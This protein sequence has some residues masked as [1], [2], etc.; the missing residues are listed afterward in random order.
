MLH[1][2]RGERGRRIGSGRIAMRHES[3]DEERGGSGVASRRELPQLEQ[4]RKQARDR[5]NGNG[6]NDR[7]YSNR[8]EYDYHDDRNEV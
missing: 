4:L 3:F 2:G 5:R 8:R 7:G 6:Y 1:S